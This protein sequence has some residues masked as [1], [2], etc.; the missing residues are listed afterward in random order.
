[1]PAETEAADW[2]TRAACADQDPDSWYPEARGDYL[3]SAHAA[4]ARVCNGSP[5][6][7]N[8]RPPCPVRL[9]C[10]LASVAV[11]R[12]YGRHGVWGGLTPDE[13]GRPRVFADAVRLLEHE[14]AVMAVGG[15][16]GT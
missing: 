1:M 6:R 12:K 8:A 13:R 15:E 10:L 3:R 4:A 7:N 16:G 9:D 5:F 11:D 2:R 14:R